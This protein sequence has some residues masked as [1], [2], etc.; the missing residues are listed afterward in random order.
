V[1][2]GLGPD[3]HRISVPTLVL[4]AVAQVLSLLDRARGVLRGWLLRSPQQPVSR[5]HDRFRSGE[6]GVD[7]VLRAAEIGRTALDSDLAPV[8]Q[9]CVVRND[10]S[11]LGVLLDEQDGQPRRV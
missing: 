4:A 2:G 3:S 5:N 6:V 11:H 8:E 9:I 1:G 7:D 10:Q